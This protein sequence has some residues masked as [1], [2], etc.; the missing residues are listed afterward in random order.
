MSSLS[1]SPVTSVLEVL[2]T[3][4]GAANVFIKYR[5]S[6]VGCPLARFC[7]LADVARTYGLPIDSLLADLEQ[8]ALADPLYS[9]G[10]HCEESD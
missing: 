4:H 10:A 5:T 7:T 3:G 2:E 1:F 6:C 8:A 9:M